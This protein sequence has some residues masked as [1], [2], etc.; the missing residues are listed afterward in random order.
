MLLDLLRLNPKKI[1]VI[2]TFGIGDVLFTTPFIVSLKKNFPA[3]FIGYLGNK[4]T[5]QFLAGHSNIDAIYEYERDE[6]KGLYDSSKIKFLS[7]LKSLLDSI[8]RE[9]FEL[10]FDFSLNRNINFL[11]MFIGIPCRVGLNYKGRMPFSTVK[12]PFDGFEGKHV[13]EH[14]LDILVSMGVTSLERELNWNVS[15]AD[16]QWADEFLRQHG[17]S[18]K[19]R[20]IGVIPGA[21][22]S[23]GPQ[24]RFRRWDAAN[25]AKL[26]DKLIEN[27]PS[28]FI[29]MGAKA[30][31]ELCAALARPGCK[32]LI[33][34][35]G[36][37]TIA[38]LAA[39]IKRCRLVVLNDGGPLHIAVAVKTRTVSVFGPVDEQVYGPYGPVSEHLV[40]KREMSCQPCYRRFRMTDC[41]HV[42]CLRN[43]SVDEV[44]EKALQLL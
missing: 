28:K 11:T 14:Y 2:N 16:R 10:V 34:S 25:Y 44:Y 37:T 15:E 43:L 26:V 33:E 17:V 42:S 40:V 38:Q 13:V 35:Q 22:E 21:G 19:D 7:K 27:S 3:C 18:D 8:K 4:R 23:W 12:I 24:A 9:R 41:Q 20:L 1:L 39:L 36:K 31:E 5:S 6:F 29:L 32:H 30:E